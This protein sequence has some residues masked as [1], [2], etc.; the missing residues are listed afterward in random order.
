MEEE[1]GGRGGGGTRD[2]CRYRER[3]G[4]GWRKCG[5]G[6]TRGGCSVKSK[7]V[8]YCRENT[9]TSDMHSGNLSPP[10]CLLIQKGP[11]V[12]SSLFVMP[13]SRWWPHNAC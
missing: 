4:R 5:Q 1:G 13:V 10:P 2:E 11:L 6:K 3:E 12:L 9:P 7:N 8:Q